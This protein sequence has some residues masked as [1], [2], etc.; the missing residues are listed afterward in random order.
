[1][2]NTLRLGRTSLAVLGLSA[3]LGGVFG[4]RVVAGASRLND[5][6]RLYTALLDAIE[7]NY[8]DD[9][10]SDRLIGSSIR[11]MLRTLDPHSS[12]F[13]TRDYTDLQDRQRGSYSG[14][15]LTIQS[16][17]G[18]I[19]VIG[20]F[21]GTPAHRVGIRPGDNIT[22]I[23]GEK[24]VG[25]SIDDAVKRLKGPRGS[26]VHV[27]ISRPPYGLTF[28]FT[29]VRDVIPLH[30]VPYSFLID[31]NTGYVRMT[32]FNE[33]TA[34]RVGEP[35]TCEQEL[36]KALK[37]MKSAGAK[38]VVLD[39]R[40]N[41]GGLLDQALAVSGL[42]L[43]KGQVVVYT[44]GRSKRD[45]ATAVTDVDG[46]F[47]QLPLIVLVSGHTA[48][49]S[50][51]V[52]GA[53]QDHDRAVIVGETTFGKGLVQ[54]ITPLRA[55][56]GYALALTTARYYT[57]SGRSIQRDYA[58]VDWV[59]YVTPKK[60]RSCD[61][62]GQDVRTTDAGRKVYGGDGITPDYCVA[63]PTASKFMSYLLLHGAFVDFSRFFVSGEPNSGSPRTVA[64]AEAGKLT[65]V[66]RDFTV[67]DAVFERFEGFLKEKKLRFTPEDLAAN[68]AE[69]S[70]QIAVDVLRQC[71]G[72]AEARKR[73]LS[74]DPQLQKALSLIDKAS[75]MLKNPQ[76]IV[77]AGVGEAKP[78]A[79]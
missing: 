26:E 38:V 14:V 18:R 55:V 20:V 40:D 67:T 22:V 13:D 27:T 78:T 12:F 36:E 73:A 61:D 72:E 8:A 28:D 77:Q 3:L 45:E 52:A 11:E 10:K 64:E 65:P 59:D 6:F 75:M 17:D 34:C 74:W 54:T 19:N 24:A 16:L 44:K 1:M 48:S 29:V 69:I 62:V 60:R 51:I 15:G 9:V 76:S 47:A 79:H 43:K 70:H 49:A 7:E 42:F 56:R 35:D 23:E 37:S 71:F 63:L 66:G 30:A 32:E 39:L 33:V 5:Q 46:R 57:P 58:S 68:R 4:G 31:K 53:L 2:N 41:P 50:E 21:E 25:M